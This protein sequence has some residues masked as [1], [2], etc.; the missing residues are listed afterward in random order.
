LYLPRVARICLAWGFRPHDVPDVAQDAFAAAWENL[1]QLRDVEKFPGWFAR[2]L[3][4]AARAA[5]KKRSPIDRSA[6]Y[7]DEIASEILR[8]EDEDALHGIVAEE[9]RR[10]IADVI[11]EIPNAAMQEV[12]RRHYVD[13]QCIE[14]IIRETG[15]PAGTVLSYLHRFRQRYVPELRRR[16]DLED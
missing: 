4:R 13:N 3:R 7:N 2:I 10:T 8:G 12:V 14:D 16:L 9:C 6:I 5:R 11:R 1:E 15:V